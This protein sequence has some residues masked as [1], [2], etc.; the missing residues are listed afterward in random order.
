MRLVGIRDCFVGGKISLCLSP[1]AKEKNRL[2]AL[3]AIPCLARKI[4]HQRLSLD[5]KKPWNFLANLAASARRGEA[6]NLS[7]SIWWSLLEEVRTFFEESYHK[8]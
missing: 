5:F 6:E 7:N 2:A 4:A 1:K 3:W 8:V